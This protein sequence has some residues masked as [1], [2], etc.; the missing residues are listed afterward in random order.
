MSNMGVACGKYAK[1]IGVTGA[2]VSRTTGIPQD[3][4]SQIFNGKAGLSADEF[5]SICAALRV[6][7]NVI[8]NNY[9]EDQQEETA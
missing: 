7:P 6:D 8:K 2:Y 9:V 1:S 5:L 4:I 3:K